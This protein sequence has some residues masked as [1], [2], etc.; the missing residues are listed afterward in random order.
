MKKLWINTNAYSGN[1]GRKAVA[2]ATGALGDNEE[3]YDVAPEYQRKFFE[4]VANVTDIS[5]YSELEDSY[6]D[7][8]ALKYY[9][10]ILKTG[11][12]VDDD[13]DYI[14]Y[15]ISS[16]LG[17]EGPCN[18]IFIQLY[19]SADDE[20]IE[21]FVERLKK[22]YKENIKDI[23]EKEEWK[24]IFH[25]EKNTTEDPVDILNIVLT[26]ENNNIVKTYL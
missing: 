19:N 1:H 21:L 23:I 12:E 9:D 17:K 3:E 2:Y 26:D 10:A 14:H 15:N 13:T 8:H 11:Q 7:N 22:F 4:E 20:T 25:E 5:S 16:Y 24:K 6:E 18:A